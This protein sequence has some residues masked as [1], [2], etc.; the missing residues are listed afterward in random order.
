MCMI[1]TLIINIFIIHLLLLFTC[2]LLFIIYFLFK[3]I[4]RIVTLFI[5]LCVYS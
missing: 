2:S 1:L 4:F 3:Y 5:Y